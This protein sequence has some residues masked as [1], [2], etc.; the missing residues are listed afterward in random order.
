MV[1]ATPGKSG[2]GRYERGG[3][4]SLRRVPQAEGFSVAQGAGL[5]LAGKLLVE[6]HFLLCSERYVQ[7]VGSDKAALGPE[8]TLQC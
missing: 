4:S 1:R 5:C 2:P 6:G 3:A 7:L 8:I